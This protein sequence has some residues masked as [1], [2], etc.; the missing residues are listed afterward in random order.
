MTVRRAA[1]TGLAVLAGL[2]TAA[3]AIMTRASTAVI[4][5]VWLGSVVLVFLV[6]FASF[7]SRTAALG[8][9]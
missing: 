3:C 1:F 2:A 9:A 8:T 5:L 4:T 7:T 6:T